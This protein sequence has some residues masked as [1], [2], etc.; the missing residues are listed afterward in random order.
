[1]REPGL[2]DAARTSLGVPGVEHIGSTISLGVRPE[3]IHCTDR[4]GANI[5]TGAIRMPSIWAPICAFTLTFPEMR[6][7]SLRGFPRSEGMTPSPATPSIS[8]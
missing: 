3:A 7:R 4:P 6:C 1:V 5:V 2:V 8:T